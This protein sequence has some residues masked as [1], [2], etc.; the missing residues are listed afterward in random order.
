MTQPGPPFKVVSN[1]TFAG[2]RMLFHSLSFLL[3]FII[4]HQV[5]WRIPNEYR[6]VWLLLSSVVFYGF[7]S[8][9]FL[10]HFIAIVVI[11]YALINMLLKERR[12]WVFVLALGLNLANLIFFKYTNSWLTYIYEWFGQQWAFELKQDLGI[13]LPLAISFYTFQIIAFIVDVWRGEVQEV[14]PLRFAVFIMFF[15]QLIAGP[16]MRHQ[17]F[18][19]QMDEPNQNGRDTKDGMGLI[20]LGIAKKVLI[21]DQIAYYINPVWANPDS[22]DAL[23]LFLTVVGFSLQIYG[24]FSGYTDMAR[25]LAKLLGYNI[26]EN[27][28]YPFLSTTFAELWRRWHV[29]LSSW[30]RDYLYIPLGGSHVSNTR[31][32]INMIIVMSL[33]GIWHGDTYNFFFWGFSQGLFLGVEKFLGFSRRTEKVYALPF[34]WAIVMAGWIV[35]AVFFRA[36]DLNSAISFFSGMVLDSG[37]RLDAITNLIDL[38]AAGMLFQVAQYYYPRFRDRLIPWMNIIV[39]LFAVILFYLVIRIER[40]A[41]EFIYFQF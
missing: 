24:D 16:I 38:I 31:Y 5:F 40:P 35:G 37:E 27:F 2:I 14:S 11:S 6:K 17:D 28:Y 33:G 34:R 30:L 20:L 29:T 1:V 9:P 19:Y 3:F 32:Y 4:V 25:G 13:L 12:R 10:F 21:S 23:T 22:Y 7:W 41:G 36:H 8:I 26:P 18:L 39:P 15:P